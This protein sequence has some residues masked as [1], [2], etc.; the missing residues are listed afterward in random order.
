MV[1]V[2]G[3]TIKRSARSLR[4]IQMLSRTNSRWYFVAPRL[5]MAAPASAA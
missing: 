4:A 3:A 5:Y 1:T 2:D